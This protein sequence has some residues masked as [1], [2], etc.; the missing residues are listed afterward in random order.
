MEKKIRE[1][2]EKLNNDCKECKRFELK[3]AKLHEYEMAIELRHQQYFY[4]KIVHDLEKIL[5]EVAVGEA[6][7]SCHFPNWHTDCDK[8]PDAIRCS[9]CELWY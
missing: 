6:K 7:K 2:I 1:F 3:R 8:I 4:R 5:N 9:N